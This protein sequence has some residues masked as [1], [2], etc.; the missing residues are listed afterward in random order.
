MDKAGLIELFTENYPDY[1]KRSIVTWSHACL[2]LS[3]SQGKDSISFEDLKMYDVVNQF[4]LTV[5]SRNSQK[6]IAN[7]LRKLAAIQGDEEVVKYYEDI[8]DDI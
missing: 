5:T 2:R 4:L 7:G 3:R 8:Y 6:T 1:A